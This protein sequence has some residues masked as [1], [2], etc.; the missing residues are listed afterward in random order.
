LSTLSFTAGWRTNNAD[1]QSSVIVPTKIE[2]LNH[3]IRWNY[4]LE[5]P[6]KD[7]TLTAELAI[8]VTARDRIRLATFTAHL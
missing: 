7:I 2:H 3:G 6:A 8:A 4:F 5:I 1:L